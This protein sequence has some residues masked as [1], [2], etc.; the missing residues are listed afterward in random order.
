MGDLDRILS[1][2]SEVRHRV[3]RIALVLGPLFGFLLLFELKPI[4]IPVAGVS[5][6]FA[7]PWP[8]PFYNITAQVFLAMVAWMLP[9][10]VQLLNVGV[11]DSIFA[12]M[13]IGLLLTLILGMPWIVH[14]VG[15]FLVPALR[16]NE[17]A[18]LRQIGIPATAL[19]AL[20]TGIGLFFLTPFTFRLLFLYVAAMRLEPVLGVQDFVTFALVYSLAFGVVFELPVFVY[21]LTRLGVVKAAAWRKHWRGAVLGA[22]VFGM[23]VTPDNSGITMLLIATPMIGLYLGGAYFASRWEARRDAAR[24][25]PRGAV[26]AG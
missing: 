20:G 25:R 19:F 18:L 16:R 21:A 6:P 15:A 9:P 8:N 5:V 1:I 17:R 12:Q 22:L 14:E 7:I 26:G 11:G 23:I 4:S 10:G 24:D 3:V 2:I 13:E